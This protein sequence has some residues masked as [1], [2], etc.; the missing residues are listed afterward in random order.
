MSA[1]LLLI[2]ALLGAAVA[3]GQPAAATHTV[4][5]GESLG[6][7]AARHGLT[8]AELMKINQIKNSNHIR[9]G[10]VLRLPAKPG[11]PAAAS[12]QPPSAPASTPPVPRAIAVLPPPEPPVP[13]AVAVMPEPSSS[14]DPAPT[15][16]VAPR[17]SA[18]T[19]SP[20]APAPVATGQPLRAL[21]NHRVTTGETLES[22]ARSW[23]SQVDQIM[24]LNRLSSSTE[25]KAGMELFIPVAQTHGADQRPSPQQP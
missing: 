10:Q 20:V 6:A 19:S 7:I 25:V 3:T 8:V 12:A 11:Q 15:G 23:Q 5:R 1:P 14:P 13:K 2:L 21:V 18:P 22:I 9:I 17:D 24:T 16:T 4:R